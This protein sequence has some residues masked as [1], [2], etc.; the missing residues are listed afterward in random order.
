MSSAA[1]IRIVYAY[2]ETLAANARTASPMMDENSALSQL[3]FRGNPQVDDAYDHFLSGWDRHR[4]KL[5]EGI[6]GAADAF[7]G[8]LRSFREVEQQLID[9]LTGERAAP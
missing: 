8:V 1:E 3:S 2:L 9:A 5:S 6:G 7:D 4:G